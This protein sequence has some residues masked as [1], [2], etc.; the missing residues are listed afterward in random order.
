MNVHGKVRRAQVTARVPRV[1][2]KD[3]SLIFNHLHGNVI[4][5]PFRWRLSREGIDRQESVCGFG[6]IGKV[7]KAAVELN[8]ILDD[9]RYLTEWCVICL[10]G[11]FD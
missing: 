3:L 7:I 5:P 10:L 2:G 4:H 11:R 8:R 1:A 6:D 9:G